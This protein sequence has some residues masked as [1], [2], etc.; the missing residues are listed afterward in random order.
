METIVNQLVQ[1]HGLSEM[2][3]RIPVCCFQFDPSTKSGIAF[4]RKTAWARKK[5]EDWFINEL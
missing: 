5:V 1:K 3:R 4:L 2:G